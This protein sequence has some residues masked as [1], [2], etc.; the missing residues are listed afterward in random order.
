MNYLYGLVL[1][2][3]VGWTTAILFYR[4]RLH[5]LARYPGPLVA[6]I[7]GFYAVYHAFIGDLHLDMLECHRKY[8]QCSIDVYV[9]FSDEMQATLYDMV[10]IS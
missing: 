4:L 8:G 2:C 6:K 9:S 7:T 10:L 3:L 1:S 5:P